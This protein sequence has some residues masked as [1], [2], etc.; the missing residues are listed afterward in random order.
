MKHPD[1]KL[2][3]QISMIKSVARIA[4]YATLAYDIQLAIIVLI[5]SEVIG[6]VE[7]LV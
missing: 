1:P 4:G 2:H 5:I 6:I 7:E 3:Q